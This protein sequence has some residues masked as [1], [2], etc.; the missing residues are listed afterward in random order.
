MKEAFRLSA[1]WAYIELAKKIGK[2]K[3]KKY[4]SAINYGSV[5]LSIEGDEFWNF[6]Y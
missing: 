1:G 5:D 4:L 3:Y 6:S 2:Q